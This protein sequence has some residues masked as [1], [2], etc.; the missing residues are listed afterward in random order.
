MVR[1]RVAGFVCPMSKTAEAVEFLMVKAVTPPAMGSYLQ[2]VQEGNCMGVHKFETAINVGQ[3]VMLPVVAAHAWVTEGGE[4]QHVYSMSG[5]CR[6][7]LLDHAEKN[8]SEPDR[9]RRRAREG[10]SRGKG[11]DVRR[12]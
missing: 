2:K 5:P 12:L 7:P 8:S 3:E 11:R 10:G 9:G 6:W 4:R 1:R